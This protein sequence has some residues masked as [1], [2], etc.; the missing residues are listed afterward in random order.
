M[1]EPYVVTLGLR[2]LIKLPYSCKVSKST[3]E[4]DKVIGTVW[5]VNHILGK[6]PQHIYP[7]ETFC[8][9]HNTIAFGRDLAKIFKTWI[10]L[11][12]IGVRDEARKIGGIGCCGRALC[13]NTWLEKFN[14]V[15]LI[16]AKFGG[17]H[18]CRVD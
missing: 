6:S 5:Q 8:P 15:T 18:K 16:H 17:Y 11:W 3:V 9:F 4:S 14:K 12:Q 7:Q 13:C 10:E 1:G 2:S